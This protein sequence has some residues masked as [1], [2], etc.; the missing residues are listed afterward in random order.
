MEKHLIALDLDGTLL[1]HKQEI[2]LKTKKVLQYLIEE[3]H[4]VMIATGRPP[5]SSI[6]FYEEIGMKTPMIN[7]NAAYISHPL[8]KNFPV[9]HSPLEMEIV[10]EIIHGIEGFNLSNVIVEVVDDVYIHA[11][12]EKLINIFLMGN[13][14]LTIGDIRENLQNN[15]TAML[16]HTKEDNYTDIR[17]HLTKNFSDIIDHRTWAAPWN[18]IEII[19]KGISKGDGVTKVADYLNIAREN[20]IAFGDEDNDLE[21]L[22]WAGTGVAMANGIDQVKEVA[23]AVTLTNNEEGV[24]SFLI[25]YFEIPLSVF[26]DEEDLNYA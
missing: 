6:E 15:P 22:Q 9:F 1:N 2:T 17:S 25:D 18:V 5:R 21:M 4:E 16:I 13:P 12:D 7:F 8:D 19:Q 24:A 10:K 23:N 14:Q 11:H 3:G 20:V 26:N